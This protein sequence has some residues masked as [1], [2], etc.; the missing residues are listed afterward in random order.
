MRIFPLMVLTEVVS[1]YTSSHM[2]DPIMWLT[3]HRILG[4]FIFPRKKNNF[5]NKLYF[6]GI[7]DII[8]FVLWQNALNMNMLSVNIWKNQ[9]DTLRD[10][11]IASTIL[12]IGTLHY[13]LHVCII[14]P[15]VILLFIL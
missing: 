10:K 2:V 14:L 6:I 8:L 7:I 11:L 13:A 5:I 3:I 12:G 1:L 9:L 4:L 15:I